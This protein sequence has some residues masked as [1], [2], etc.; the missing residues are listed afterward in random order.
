MD[1]AGLPGDRGFPS[2]GKYEVGSVGRAVKWLATGV[3]SVV[4]FGLSLWL[5]ATIKLSF[6]PK[7]D[8]DRWVVNAAFATAMA[9]CVVACGAWWAGRENRPRSADG[10]TGGAGQQNIESQGSFLLGSGARMKARDINVTVNPAQ[11]QPP[12]GDEV[13]LPKA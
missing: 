12:G 10:S 5:A 1:G 3:A 11:V 2:L 6:L 13:G 4:A 8:A 7:A 9:A